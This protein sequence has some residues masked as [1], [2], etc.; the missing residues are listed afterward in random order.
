[1]V[2]LSADS[3]DFTHVVVL[4]EGT[5]NHGCFIEEVLIVALKYGNKVSGDD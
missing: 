1:M 4:D 3:I 2:W 5:I